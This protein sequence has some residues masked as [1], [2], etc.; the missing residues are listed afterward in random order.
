MIRLWIVFTGLL[1]LALFPVD[2]S[3]WSPAGHRLTGAIAD[4][5]LNPH[6]RQKVKEELGFTLSEAAVWADCVRSVV[7]RKD[8]TFEYAPPRP[9]YAAPCPL[10]ETPAEK[11][12]MIDYVARNLDDC[13]APTGTQCHATYHYTDVPIERDRYVQGSFGTSPHDVVGA[14]EAA[15]AKLEGRPVPAPFSIKDNKEALFMLSH[16]VGDLQQPLHVGA[17][18]LSDDGNI[19]DP[20]RPGAVFEATSGGNA[21]ETESRNL[22]A[23]WDDIVPSL[24][25]PSPEVLASLVARA[26]KLGVT[27][28]GRT[29][30]P[31]EKLSVVWASET[32]RKSK[33]AFAGLS[34]TKDPEHKNRWNISFKDRKAYMKAK[35]HLQEEQLVKSGARIAELLNTIWP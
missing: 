12:R 28:V 18:Y 26:R 1:G 31:L 13:G 7:H 5:L 11:D 6:A 30:V 9:E 27:R 17:I 23:V 14:I 33:L 4:Q 35:D 10:F 19:V 32:L 29:H 8:G 34:Y 25:P 21:L 24:E 20:A 15:I 2:A 3:A 16:F 22:H